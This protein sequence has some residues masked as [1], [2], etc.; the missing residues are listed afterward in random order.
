M[1]MREPGPIDATR[2]DPR[3][4]LSRREWLERSLFTL[5]ALAAAGPSLAGCASEQAVAIGKLPSAPRQRST[6]P[7]PTAAPTLHPA[8]TNIGLPPG[9]IPRTTWARANPIP[10]RMEPMLPVSRITIHHDGMPPI[11][12]RNKAQAMARLEQ[13]RTA[14]LGRGFGDIGY[15]YIIDP[16]G[17]VWQ[18]R[19]LAWQGA[20]VKAQNENNLGIMVMGNFE[21]QRPTQAQIASAQRFVKSQMATYRVPV[22]RVYTH[23]EL[24]QTACPG[25]NL[26]PILVA[27]RKPGGAMSA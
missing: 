24:A 1:T 26:Q 3:P 14:H 8:P 25:R 2:G 18:G 16:D 4:A 7:P 9:V 13:I 19:P 15:H 10:S 27:S 17:N 12:I 6:P 11:S 20:H 21:V 22:G 5:G 23:K